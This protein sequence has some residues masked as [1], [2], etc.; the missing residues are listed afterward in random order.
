[1]ATSCSRWRKPS[2]GIDGSRR[3]APTIGEALGHSWLTTRPPGCSIRTPS[4]A[5]PWSPQGRDDRR[6]PNDRA[7]LLQDRGRA[8][9]MRDGASDTGGPWRLAECRETTDRCMS[10]GHKVTHGCTSAMHS[11]CPAHSSTRGHRRGFAPDVAV[12]PRGPAC[13]AASD[14]PAAH[15]RALTS[16][17][18]HPPMRRPSSRGPAAPSAI[19]LQTWRLARVAQVDPLIEHVPRSLVPAHEVF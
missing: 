5:R 8:C 12:I 9:P 16:G 7:G 10:T 15:G 18:P 3:L 11:T 17:S 14:T 6:L 13:T 2:I 1:M 4:P 19:V